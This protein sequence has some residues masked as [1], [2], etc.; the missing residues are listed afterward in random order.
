LIYLVKFGLQI[1]TYICI[2]MKR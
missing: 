2:I 1:L